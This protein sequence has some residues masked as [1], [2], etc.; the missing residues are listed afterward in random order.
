MSTS[1]PCYRNAFQARKR[2]E[3]EPEKEIMD[4][5]LEGK[6]EGKAKTGK[7]EDVIEEAFNY[8]F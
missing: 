2:K 6:K 4:L 5:P 8:H 3:E 7:R 1:K